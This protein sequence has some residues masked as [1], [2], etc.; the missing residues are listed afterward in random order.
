[1]RYIFDNISHFFKEV[2]YEEKIY[3]IVL[4]FIAVI[5]TVGCGKEKEYSE[6]DEY[7]YYNESNLDYVSNQQDSAKV[8]K[9]ILII[10]DG[11]GENQVMVTEKYGLL[12]KI[13]I[14]QM[15][16]Y[17]CMLLVRKVRF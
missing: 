3:L 10:G 7:G 9:I 17:L 12:K 5:F 16:K 14:I 11:M 15:L 13:D 6:Y 2:K 4:L 8:K 1:M